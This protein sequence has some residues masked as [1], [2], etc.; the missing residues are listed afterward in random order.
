MVKK[1]IIIDRNTKTLEK[2]GQSHPNFD[3]KLPRKR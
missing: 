3:P 2:Y 1:V